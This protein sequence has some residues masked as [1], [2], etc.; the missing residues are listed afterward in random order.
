M[1]RIKTLKEFEDFIKNQ[2][3]QTSMS[4]GA[5]QL[6][7]RGHA[8][9]KYQIV[10]T[11]ARNYNYVDD[12]LRF[13]KNLLSITKSKLIG[14]KLGSVTL[15]L[16]KTTDNYLYDW[17]LQFQLKHLEVPSRL[18]DFSMNEL[19][20]LYFCLSNL[21]KHGEDGHVWIYP[22][23]RDFSI[24]RDKNGKLKKIK[25][26]QLYLSAGN[27]SKNVLAKINSLNPEKITL[28]HN[29]YIHDDW[30]SQIGERRKAAQNG[31]FIVKP[32]KTLL[33]PLENHA[34]GTMMQKLI[35]DGESKSDIYAELIEKYNFDD[36]RVLPSIPE[37]TK[38][39]IKEIIYESKNKM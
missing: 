15:H 11:I 18:I 2:R 9:D 20:A 7:F 31:K 12:I 37:D 35:I 21:D 1:I 14:N 33:V 13:E 36:E 5:I 16:P 22:A 26:Q 8:L 3:E 10:P 6:L 28:L 30:G 29:S 19:T 34:I 23:I 32:N 17:Y 24:F 25:D 39:L 4:L 38:E 27:N